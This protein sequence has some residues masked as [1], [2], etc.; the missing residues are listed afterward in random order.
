MSIRFISI[1]CPDCGADLSIEENRTQ[2][3]CTY[4]GTMVLVNNENEYVYRHIDEAGVAQAETDRIVKLKKIEMAEKY[5]L[6][7]EKSKKFRITLSLTFAV[8][9]V[10]T[11]R[12]RGDFLL[13]RQCL[14]EYLDCHL[15]QSA[16]VP[17]RRADHLHPDG[18]DCPW[19][20]GG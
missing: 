11:L 19:L 5:R 6:A 14:W 13:Q 10:I 17:Q 9:A 18:G 20:S 4:C 1:K 8:I 7:A 2:A 12:A 15:R 3:F 16:H